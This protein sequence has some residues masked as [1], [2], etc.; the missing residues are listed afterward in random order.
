LAYKLHKRTG[1]E[2]SKTGKVRKYLEIRPHGPY[3][4][5]VYEGPISKK[6]GRPRRLRMYLHRLVAETYLGYSKLHVNHIN[7]DKHVN[8]LRNLEYVTRGGNAEHA[9]RT[10]LIQA[11]G[12]GNGR[13]KLSDKQVI[14]IL[15]LD[16]KLKNGTGRERQEMARTLADRYSVSA[17]HIRNIWSGDT[18]AHLLI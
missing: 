7:G 1:L 17:G 9:H 3:L 13:A 5:V 18:W 16:P 11:S 4:E 15:R 6:T 14:R 8:R 12:S 10:G 2:V